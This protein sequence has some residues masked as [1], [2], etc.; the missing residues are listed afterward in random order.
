MRIRLDTSKLYK[1]KLGTINTIHRDSSKCSIIQEIR[2][3]T[4]QI[5]VLHTR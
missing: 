4:E 5:I 2:L 1:Q 3:T